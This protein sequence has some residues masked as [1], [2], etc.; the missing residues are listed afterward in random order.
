MRPLHAGRLLLVLAALLVLTGM[1]GAGGALERNRLLIGLARETE[2]VLPIHL[3]AEHARRDAGLTLDVVS[4]GGGS[5]AAQAIAS[6]S[7]QVAAISLD[8]AVRLIEAGQPVQIFYAGV[9][10]VLFE[11]YA[12]PEI[13]SWADL[14][15]RTMGVSTFGSLSEH[16]TR[17]VL[18]RHAL[19]AGRDVTLIQSGELATGFAALRAGRLDSVVLAHPFTWMAQ[20][21]GF[22]RLG[23]QAEEVADA[24]PRIV[25]VAKTKLLAGEPAVFRAFLAAYVTA[26]RRVRADRA[27]TID[28]LVAR[29]K[30]DR[31]YAKRLYP[32]LIAGFDER[33]RVPESVMP[34]FWKI[35]VAAGDVSA[36]WPE[37]R[38][39][40]RRYLDSFESWAPPQ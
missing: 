36:P 25:F 32:E 10:H 24:W 8:G 33:G 31:R 28:Q 4:F 21:A 37:A 23:I 22:T 18:G 39:L 12:R 5:R 9:S 34:L 30:L 16:L 2:F 11:W 27:G 1:V 6:D 20:E 26:L 38:Y 17:Y 3:A 35:S 29:Y 14:R 13:R 15:G 19:E 7:I 40:D